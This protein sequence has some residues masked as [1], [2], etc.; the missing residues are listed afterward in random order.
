MYQSVLV[1]GASSG[2]GEATAVHL[3]HNGFRVFAAARRMD[4]LKDL[5][6]LADGRITPLAMDVTD[7]ASVDAAFETISN[8]DLPLFGL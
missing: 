3:A 2:I 5:E 1:T 6:G 7:A 8:A 4:K